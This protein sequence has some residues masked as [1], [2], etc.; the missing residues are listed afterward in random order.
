MAIGTSTRV[1]KYMKTPKTTPAR[2]ASR[3]FS[4]ARLRIHSGWMKTRMTPTRKTPTT[5]SGKICFTKRQVSHNHCCTSQASKRRASGS[6]SRQNSVTAK[7][8][9]V[10]VNAMPLSTTLKPRAAKA[11]VATVKPRAMGVKRLKPS[12]TLP[13]PRQAKTPMLASRPIRI[14]PCRLK[15]SAPMASLTG[16]QRSRV[17]W[18]ALAP[19]QDSSASNSTV[20][21]KSSLSVPEISSATSAPMKSSVLPG[22]PPPSAKVWVSAR[23]ATSV[24]RKTMAMIMPMPMPKDS[25]SRMR[26]MANSAP[27]ATPV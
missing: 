4:P 25:E 18:M 9:P 16:T 10:I 14:A 12:S 24:S 8:R 20:F 11:S 21:R 23:R 27:S 13:R 22:M 6:R 7:V 15:P 5:S 17:C 1:G 26:A 2:L 3:V 19:C